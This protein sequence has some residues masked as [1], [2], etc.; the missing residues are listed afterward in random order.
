MGLKM[1]YTIWR[2]FEMYNETKGFVKGVGTGLAVGM[3]VAGMGSKAMK[4]N[5][6]VKRKANQAMRKVNGVLDNMEY[7]FK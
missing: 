3:A 2:V 4:N 1:I 6:Q 7:L 5:R